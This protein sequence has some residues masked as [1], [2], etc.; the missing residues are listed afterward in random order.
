MSLQQCVPLIETDWGHGADS[1]NDWKEVIV[2]TVYFPFSFKFWYHAAL[3]PADSVIPITPSH[4]QDLPIL[5]ELHLGINGL[6]LV[7]RS[8]SA[9]WER[10][11]EER[12]G[13]KTC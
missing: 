13:R 1:L 10:D 7:A 9:V 6:V 4:S 11:K 8:K 12:T 5:A 3:C 2:W